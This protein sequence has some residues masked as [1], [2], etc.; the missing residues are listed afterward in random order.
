VSFTVD[1][2]DDAVHENPEEYKVEI[3]DYTT[4]GYEAVSEGAT[5]VTTTITD[6]DHTPIAQNSEVTFDE[7]KD[8]TTSTYTFS[9]SDFGYSDA[10]NDPISEIK[11]TSLA[12]LGTL[13]NNGTAVSVNDVISATDIDNGLL[14][15]Q[16][17]DKDDSGSDEYLGDTRPDNS[18]VQ[19]GDLGDQG[20]DYATFNFSVSDGANWSTDAT[21]TIDVNAKADTPTLTIQAATIESRQD[22]TTDNA[23]ETTSG[24]TVTAYNADGTVGAIS[25]HDVPTG[26]G[27]YGEVSGGGRRGNPDEISYDTNLNQSEKI[28]IEFDNAVDS[29]DM[30]LRWN[31]RDEGGEV[32]FFNNGISLGTVSI[33][34]GSDGHD[35][36]FNFKPTNGDPFDEIH[37]YSPGADKDY[38]IDSIHYDRTG[39]SLDGSVVVKADSSVELNMSTG[40]AD[41]DGSES[42]KVE[43]QDIPDG[44]TITDGTNSFTSNG[45]TSSVD[46]SRWYQ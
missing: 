42:L 45:R 43:L 12:A 32:A 29:V 34:G 11:I 40:L 4:G 31:A 13:Y 24:F 21:M 3:T 7:A 6:D 15:Y 33:P 38:L 30:E 2:V 25:T 41:T 28:V 8:T 1:N 16:P 27:V 5:S 46:I 9:K 22:I 20:E 10:D 36:P 26:F 35:G 17:A 18:V 23:G 39:S 37:F 19:D 14:T 44:F